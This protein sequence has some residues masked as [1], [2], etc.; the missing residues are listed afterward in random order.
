[1]ADQVV[2]SYSQNKMREDVA[3]IV[4]NIAPTQTPFLTLCSVGM[5][6]N[7]TVEWQQDDL[8]PPASNAQV[9][10]A[11]APD[12]E[13]T[14]TTVESNYCQIFSKTVRVSGTAQAVDW[15]G[16]Q[17]ELAYQLSKKSKEMKRDAE[18]ALIGS[19]QTGEIGNTTTA[20]QMK[21]FG[22]LADTE[23]DG[24]DA[25]YYDTVPTGGDPYYLTEMMVLDASEQLYSLGAD[26]DIL[27][28][29]PRDATQVAS[30]TGSAGRNRDFGQDRK[31]VNVVD[32]YVSP[33][34]ELDVITN[35]FLFGEHSAVYDSEYMEF[36]YLRTP[37]KSSLSKTGDSDK[38]QLLMEGTLKMGS[39]KAAAFISGLNT[40]AP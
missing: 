31:I 25:A 12:S 28:V 8:A 32:L 7:R 3:D 1:M 17:D 29:T 24:T 23:I 9:E 5:A 26:P 36:S 22:T 11:D 38:E 15:Y 19:L 20:R 33:Y 2:E 10:G 34:G 14:P 6:H 39:T 37:E 21:S 4:Y 27:M 13:F 40:P 18:H 16:R 30:W 35:R